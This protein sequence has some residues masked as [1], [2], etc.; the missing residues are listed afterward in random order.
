ML[1]DCE[2]GEGGQWGPEKSINWVSQEDLLTE[3]SQVVPCHF[4]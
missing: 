1:E 4:W 2:V 3:S